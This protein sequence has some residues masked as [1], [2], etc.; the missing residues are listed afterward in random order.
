MGAALI[1]RGAH[2]LGFYRAPDR[3]IIALRRNNSAHLHRPWG[4]TTPAHAMT[5]ARYPAERRSAS[6][7]RRSH[8]NLRQI[9]IGQ[10]RDQASREQRP[11]MLVAVDMPSLW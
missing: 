2:I 11:R 7:S 3:N 6:R 1:R 5:V 4:A 10:K 9:A 8:A